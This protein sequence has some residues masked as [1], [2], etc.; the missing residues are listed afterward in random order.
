MSPGAATHN[1]DCNRRLKEGCSLEHIGP[2]PLLRGVAGLP[3][4]EGELQRVKPLAQLSVA[5]GAC[6]CV[7]EL[8]CLCVRA[9]VCV[10]ACV[11]V[12]VCACVYVRA[13]VCAC[14]CACV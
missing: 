11:R 8:L 13:R 4:L 7:E 5:A 1:S 12:H 6:F 3:P 14:V 9:R 10:C 2:Q